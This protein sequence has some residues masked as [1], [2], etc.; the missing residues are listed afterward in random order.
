MV[1]TQGLNMSFGLFQ[2]YYEKVLLPTT[3][4]SQIA[5]IGSVQ[6]CFLFFMALLVSPAVH[7]GHFRACFCG[8]SVV[9]F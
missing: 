1:N 3:A 5:G 9:L 7:H 6:I 4:S 8:G 2:A